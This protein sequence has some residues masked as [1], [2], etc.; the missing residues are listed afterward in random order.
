MFGYVTVRISDV[1]ETNIGL[2]TSVT[3]YKTDKGVQLLHNSD[4]QPNR[5]EAAKIIYYSLIV[6]G[7]WMNCTK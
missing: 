7:I 2:A 3:K 5:I 4:I 1:A 6:S